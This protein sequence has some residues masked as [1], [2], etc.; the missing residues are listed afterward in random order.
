MLPIR[1]LTACALG[2]GL[3]AVLLAGA[4]RAADVD[5]LLPN[6]TE[7]VVGVNVKQILNSGVVKRFG[8]DAIKQ[9]LQSDDKVQKV[10]EDLG[11]DPFK[12]LDSLLVALPAV[13]TDTDIDRALVIVRGNFDITKAKAK[14]LALSKDDE[15]KDVIKLASKPDGL[16]GKHEFWEISPPDANKSFF[17]SLFSK[18]TLLVAPEADM[19]INAIEQNDGRK[20]AALKNKDMAGLLARLDSKQSA[21][22]G[23]VGSALDKSPLADQDEAKKIIEK[24]TDASIGVNVEKDIS[25]EIG[26]TAKGATEAKDL[27]DII[28][29]GL[30]QVLGIAALLGG[31]NKQI[32]PL[33]D[34]LKTIKPTT[35]DKTITVKATVDSET[36]DKIVPKP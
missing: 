29:D 26:V 9:M 11:F 13:P 34:I 32:A 10:L 27:E 15:T 12:D 19:L 16:G 7:I 20:K 25:L 4:V 24:L 33:I 1:R 30:N 5:K 14:A 6:D 28:K 3:T 31:N 35:K 23:V 36:L 2:L 8:E 22:V 21:Y 18:D 17:V